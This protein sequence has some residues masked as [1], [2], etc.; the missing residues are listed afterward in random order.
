MY[1]YIFFISMLSGGDASLLGARGTK[2][3]CSTA[4]TNFNV[5]N[6]ELYLH[7]T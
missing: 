6:T 4:Q 1:I 2:Q 5:D 7:Y 3:K